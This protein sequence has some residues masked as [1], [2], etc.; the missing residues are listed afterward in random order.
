VLQDGD[1]IHLVMREENAGHAYS[2]IESG[3]E[4]D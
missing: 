3:P 4:E 1:L 2:H